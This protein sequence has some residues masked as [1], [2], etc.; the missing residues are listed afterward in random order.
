[1]EI[2]KLFHTFVQ[3]LKTPL[4][5]AFVFDLGKREDERGFFFQGIE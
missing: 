5:G 2:R 3:F 4:K 1:L